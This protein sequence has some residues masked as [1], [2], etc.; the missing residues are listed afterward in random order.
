MNKIVTILGSTGSVGKSALKVIKS[1]KDQFTVYGLVCRKNITILAEQIK[2]F[3][4]QAVA[5]EDEETLL[6]EEYQV[7]KSRFPELIFYEREE[8][9]L[10]LVTHSVDILV[11]AIKGAAGLKPTLTALPYVKRVSLANKESLVMAGPLFLE[12]IKKYQ[13]ELIPID[14]EHQAIF[15]LLDNVPLE[16]LNKIILTASGGSLWQVSPKEFESISLE[17][18]LD[19]PTWQMGQKITVDSATLMNKGLEVIE[20]HY[21]FNVDYENIEIIIHPES[22]IHSMIETVDGVIY[23]QMSVADMSLPIL[24]SLQYPQR[25][26]NNF[27]R[28]DFKKI[29]SL[30]FYPCDCKKFPAVG[31]CYSVGQAGGLMPAVLNAANEVAVE[32]FLSG[33][34]SFL[35]IIAIVEKIINTQKN[36]A[37]PSLDDILVADQEARIISKK[38]IEFKQ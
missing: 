28:L 31:L 33:Q 19:H 35:S 38:N 6:S 20:A 14:S 24:A 3:H 12:E 32:A 10:D 13:V 11:S 1:F 5:V 25:I 21:L 7:L 37:N 22:L 16:D 8:G 4:P 17:R 18:V 26:K 9:I 27:G 2:E 23:A 15:S 30:N 34:I 29:G 36:I